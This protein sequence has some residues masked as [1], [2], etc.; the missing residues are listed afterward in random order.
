MSAMIV[1]SMIGGMLFIERGTAPDII[2][3]GALV[4]EDQLLPQASL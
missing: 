4:V 2:S 3:G 1:S